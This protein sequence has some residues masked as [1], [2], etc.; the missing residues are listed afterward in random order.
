[1]TQDQQELITSATIMWVLLVLCTILV[2]LLGGL[3]LIRKSRRQI[4]GE[5]GD[6]GKLDQTVKR[7]LRT[8][9]KT[10]KRSTEEEDDESGE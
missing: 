4:F 10:K 7:S 5:T 1:M 6:A 3:V 8:L 9:P 2:L